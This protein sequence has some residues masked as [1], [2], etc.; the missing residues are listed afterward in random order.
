MLLDVMW[1]L[2]FRLVRILIMCLLECFG[3]IGV[4]LKLLGMVLKIMV[5]FFRVC[6]V[7]VGM[8][9]GSVCFLL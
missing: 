5:W 2:V 4:V 6:M 8:V 3:L 1:L 9:S 7:L